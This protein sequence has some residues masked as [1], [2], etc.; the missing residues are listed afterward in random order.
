MKA[1][2]NI[3]KRLLC[4]QGAG[5]PVPKDNTLNDKQTYNFGGEEGY[6]T[7]KGQGDLAVIH[8]PRT[9]MAPHVLLPSAQ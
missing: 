3:N 1:A 8:M 5:L 9:V 2:F 7:Y 4:V 6:F